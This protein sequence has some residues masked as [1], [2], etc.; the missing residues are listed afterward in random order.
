IKKM[1]EGSRETYEKYTSPL[2]IG[3]MVMPGEHYGCCVDGYEYSRFGTYH[4]ADHLGIGVDRTKKGTGFVKQYHEIN[5]QKYDDISTCPEELLL[6]FHHVPYTHLLKTGKTV[7]QHIYDAHFE[8]VDEV[9]HMIEL[10]EEIR[11]YIETDVWE[12]VSG[13]FRKQLYNAKEWR[14][15]INSY[16]Y[17][18]SGIKDAYGRKIY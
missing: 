5:C 7:I 4:R 15:Q 18:K 8:G 11:E 1:I 13:R 12:E 14:D 10:W 9:E 16:F 17:R 6:F 3:W 2:G